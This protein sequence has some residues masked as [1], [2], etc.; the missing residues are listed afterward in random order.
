[1]TKPRTKK[2][3]MAYWLL[4]GER[5][6]QDE[7]WGETLSGGRAPVGRGEEGGDRTVDEFV[8]Y[9]AGYANDLVQYA[10]HFGSSDGKLDI[11][12]KVGALCVAAIEQHGAPE[13]KPARQFVTKE[14]HGTLVSIPLEK[15]PHETQVEGVRDADKDIRK[16][17]VWVEYGPDCKGQ[18]G[19]RLV[20]QRH[21][22]MSYGDARTLR[23]LLVDIP[24]P[25]ERCLRAHGR[26]TATTCYE[27]LEEV[28]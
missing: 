1:M 16:R 13:R 7:R 5:D 20:I 22:K 3:E 18:F 8:L 19:E 2:R 26:C 10:S 4:D 21:L 11:M 24:L 14:E 25:C 27:P 15:D 9:V 6:Y 28:R 17:E 23:K 12:R